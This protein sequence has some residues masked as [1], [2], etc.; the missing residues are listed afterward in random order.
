ML[1]T[2]RVNTAEIEKDFDPFFLKIKRERT[3]INTQRQKRK[4][5]ENKDKSYQWHRTMQD[6]SLWKDLGKTYVPQRT[7]EGR[8]ADEHQKK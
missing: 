7:S 5:I 2:N 6:R 3:A 4:K 8:N 1:S